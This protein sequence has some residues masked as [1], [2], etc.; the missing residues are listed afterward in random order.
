M[1]GRS[2]PRM[3]V[4][5]IPARARRKGLPFRRGKELAVRVVDIGPRGVSLACESPLDRDTRLA[6]TLMIPAQRVIR[7]AG[8]VRNL[9]KEDR[10]YV[11]GVEFTRLSKRDERFLA[12]NMLEIAGISVLE[13]SPML[14]DRVRGLRT[15]MEFTVSELSELSGVP[16]QRIV[17]IEFGME[18]TPPE[19]VLTRIAAALG[20]SLEDLVG[21]ERSAGAEGIPEA[22]ASRVPFPEGS[23]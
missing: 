8:I 4:R 21:T 15:A 13:N 7:C 10:G 3:K 19:A 16:A 12:R 20:V 9:R 11:L 17:Q 6:I 1:E 14:K 18:R 2:S 23:F 5:N 22:L